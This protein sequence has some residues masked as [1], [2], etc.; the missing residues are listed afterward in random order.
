MVTVGIDPHTQVHVAVAIGAD[1]RQIGKDLTVKNGPAVVSGLLTGARAISKGRPVTWA[2]EDGR[3]FA[4]RLADGL[5]LAGVEVVWVPTRL[6]AAHRKLHAAT[7]AKWDAV[8]AAAAAYAGHRQ[9]EP[10]ATPH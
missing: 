3:R 4:R 10:G 5:L 8:D 2:I 9:P 1:G 6:T 7:G